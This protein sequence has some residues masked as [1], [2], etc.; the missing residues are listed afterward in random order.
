MSTEKLQE[1]LHKQNN[2]LKEIE[3]AIYEL[4]NDC[5]ALSAQSEEVKEQRFYAGEANAFQIALDLLN[6]I[7]Q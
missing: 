1:L 5:L 6:T 7:K 4:K 2:S 3:Q